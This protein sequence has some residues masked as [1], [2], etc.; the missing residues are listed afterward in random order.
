VGQKA[1]ALLSQDPTFLI[2]DLVA[3][4][5]RVGQYF[6]EA[7]VWREP[8]VP[9]PKSVRALKLVDV[10]ALKADFI[11]SCL[12]PGPAH[13][14]E[15]HFAKNNK[16]VFSNASAWR[17]EKTVPLLIPE[18]NTEHLILLDRQP[19]RG[20]I[21]TNPNC[22][23]TGIALALAPLR[24]IGRMQHVGIVT[25]QSISGAGYPGISAM[26][27]L[28]NTV[29]HIPE[30]AEKISLEIKKILGSS[31]KPAQFTS[32]VQ[33][34]RVPT[35]Y[36]HTASLQIIFKDKV[37]SVSALNIYKK[38]NRT[39]PNLFILHSKEGRPQVLR[40]LTHDDMRV[41]IGHVRESENPYILSMV[42]STHNL[43]RGAAGAVLANMKTFIKTQ[44]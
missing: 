17:M 16:I 40:D 42:V 23:A 24:E 1:I 22:A 21:I 34:H 35:Q 18:I 31:D 25:L 7:C 15:L 38:W 41:H 5:A 19:T 28:A 39:F 32:T 30:E 2:T 26:D 44:L 4:S 8:L 10:G 27:I 6:R 20:K 14:L 13:D 36:G 43:V 11:I 37:S 3:S 29:P 9:M 33:V 12:P